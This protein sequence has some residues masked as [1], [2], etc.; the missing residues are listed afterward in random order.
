MVSLAS[1]AD[2]LHFPFGRQPKGRSEAVQAWID[3]ST[4]KNNSNN[5]KNSSSTTK[6]RISYW[7]QGKLGFGGMQSRKTWHYACS[8]GRIQVRNDVVMS[9]EVCTDEADTAYIRA[10][11]TLHFD[12][13]GVQN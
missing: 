7:Q 9:I 8:L 10:I 4:N 2:I 11:T 13:F 3:N 6:N 12:A 5:N 1:I